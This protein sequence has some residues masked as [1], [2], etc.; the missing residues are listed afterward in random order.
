MIDPSRMDALRAQPLRSAAIGR[1]DGRWVGVRKNWVHAEVRAESGELLF[2]YDVQPEEHWLLHEMRLAGGHLVAAIGDIAPCGLCAWDLARGVTTLRFDEAWQDEGETIVATEAEA[3]RALVRC[4]GGFA[5]V[6]VAAAVISEVVV[7]PGTTG[8][9]AW[10]GFRERLFVEEW[11]DSGRCVCIRRRD[12]DL[13]AAFPSGDC[14][15]EAFLPSGGGRLVAVQGGDGSV[16]V[17]DTDT[18]SEHVIVQG[19][20]VLA[21]S[22]CGRWLALTGSLVDLATGTHPLAT[23]AI[24]S[25]EAAAFDLDRGELLLADDRG[26]ERLRLP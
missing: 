2:T 19:S 12:G 17:R 6:D 20:R 18:W 10:D 24:P 22:P 4:P 26:L 15:V 5:F 8:A 7:V 16:V 21:A 3:P 14:E 9:A 23:K 1:V 25:A 11:G 13:L